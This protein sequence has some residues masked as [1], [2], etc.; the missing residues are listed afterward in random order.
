MRTVG[1]GG[2]TAFGTTALTGSASAHEALEIPSDYLEQ[3][4]E[5]GANW[6]MDWTYLAGIGAVETQHGQYEDGCETSSAGARGPM[7]FMPSTWEAYGVDGTGDGTTDI[8]DFRDAIPSAANYLEANGAP[9]NWDDALYAYN[10]R[11]SYV[12]HVTE[13]AARY[14]DQYGSGDGGGGDTGGGGGE[15]AEFGDGDRITP[16]TSLNT[17]HR[18]G[19]ESDVLATMQPG[20]AGE[21]VNGPESAD[22]YTWWGV[23][24]LEND[25]WGWSVERYLTA[26]DDSDGGGGSG[27]TQGPDF[28]WPIDGYITSP[29][30]DRSGHLA[31]DFGN[32]RIVGTP[33]YAA[34]D[35][36]VDVVGYEATGCGNYVKLGHDSGYQTMYCHL[37]S[38]RVSEGRRVSRGEQLGGMGDTGRS[39]APHLHFTIERNRS[40]LPIPGGDGR[41][42]NAGEAIPRD[43]DGI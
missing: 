3:Y 1:T 9:E 33:V 26:A 28:T 7:Q 38:V 32:D 17:R 43:Y 37:N 29:Y 18:P 42:V 6:G 27:G 19:T 4:R 30:G 8:C 22:G 12:E 21:I 24:W 2:L 41:T 31:V 36:V 10:P 5:T 35:G 39:T 16:T 34:R 11:W 20:S 40:H 25:L 13:H 15:R 23:H 14:R